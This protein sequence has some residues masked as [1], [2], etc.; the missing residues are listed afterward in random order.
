M[1][2]STVDASQKVDKGLKRVLMILQGICLVIIF[3]A[4]FGLM[5]RIEVASM[6]WPKWVYVKMLVWLA[7]GLSPLFLRKAWFV[8]FAGNTTPAKKLIINFTVLF[9]LL[10][11]AVFTVRL[12]Y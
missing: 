9:A 4:G 11:L 2:Y 3:V 7:L 5:A 10:L 1:F 8:K 12:K 6:P